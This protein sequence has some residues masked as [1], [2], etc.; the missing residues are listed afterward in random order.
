MGSSPSWWG[1]LGIQIRH[2]GVQHI[3]E[4]GLKG[5]GCKFPWFMLSSCVPFICENSW[6]VPDPHFIIINKLTYIIVFDKERYINVF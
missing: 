5:H 4:S 3:G 2:I 6:E 1:P